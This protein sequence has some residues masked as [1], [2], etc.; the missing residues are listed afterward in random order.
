MSCPCKKCKIEFLDEANLEM[1]SCFVENIQIN[2]LFVNFQN[3]MAEKDSIND[4]DSVILKE[5]K[6]EEQYCAD[7]ESSKFNEEIRECERTNT[8]TYTEKCCRCLKCNKIF[9]CAH[10]RT[11]CY[12][13]IILKICFLCGRII[14]FEEYTNEIG[15]P[16]ER[17]SPFLDREFP[18]YLIASNKPI[19]II[20]EKN[21]PYCSA[22]CANFCL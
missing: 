21:Q 22:V 10:E 6:D 2:D 19:K 9:L 14:Y 12:D 17:F 8:W 16:F 15:F 13:C 3:K 4:K 18:G 7:L 5:Q 11:V 1:P 20:V